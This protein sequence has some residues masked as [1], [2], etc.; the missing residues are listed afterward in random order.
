[1]NNRFIRVIK[2]P[3][4][5]LLV[6]LDKVAFMLSDSLFLRIKYFLI[7][8]KSLNLKN[9]KT[10]N[11]KIQWLKLNDRKPEYTRMVDK[12]EAKNFVASIIGKEYIIQTL[13][14]FDKFED[15]DFDKLPRQ[16]VLKTTHD[17][18]GVVICKDK[19]TFDF[20]NAHKKLKKHLSNNPY[21]RTREW[22]YKDVKPRIIVEEYMVAEKKGELLDYK[23]MLFNA[24]IKS[25]FVCSQRNLKTEL[26]VDFFNEDWQHLP[27]E[28][29]YKNSEITLQKPQMF[30]EM[31]VLAEKLAFNIQAPF[32][33]I[34]FY[35]VNKQIYFGEITLYPGGGWEE[36]T[37]E[38]WDFTF[39]SWIEL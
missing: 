31:K 8:N 2:N 6:L 17:S 26:K 3:I 37:P 33:R 10:F 16:F 7:M 5:V 38:K 4:L 9:P 39:G 36:F 21:Y 11:E 27:F 18:G 25:V 20:T 29:Y 30:I 23:F 13:G 28:R 22:P 1:M 34:D 35:E 12:V 24:K 14:V 19:N 15:I 32:V